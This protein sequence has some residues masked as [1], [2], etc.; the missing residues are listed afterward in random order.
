MK[1]KNEIHQNILKYIE[2]RFK[3]KNKDVFQDA[4]RRTVP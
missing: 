2:C 4:K 1:H 3:N